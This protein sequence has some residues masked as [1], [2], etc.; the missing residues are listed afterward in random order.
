MKGAARRSD[1]ELIQAFNSGDASA[2]EGLYARYER[3]ILAF[4]VRFLGD[5]EAAMDVA[6]E[7]FLAAWR[8]LPTWQPGGSFKVWLYTVAVNRARTARKRRM[9]RVRR[10]AAASP[11]LRGEAEPVERAARTEEAERVRTALASLPPSQRAC[12]VLRFDRSLGYAEIA[13][14]MGITESG[15]R[16]NAFKA[17]AALRRRLGSG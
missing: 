17:L 7:V 6:Q 14:A 13:K 2:F 4:L 12:L 11:R 10:E 5:A 3:A 16:A 1:E 8:K 15:A 9:T